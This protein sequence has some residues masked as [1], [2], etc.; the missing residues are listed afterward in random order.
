MNCDVSENGNA[1]EVCFCKGLIR[2]ESGS[3]VRASWAI[4]PFGILCLPEGAD[5]DLAFITSDQIA[6]SE[7]VTTVDLSGTD[8]ESVEVIVGAVLRGG[9]L[10]KVGA[11]DSGEA[12]LFIML[13]ELLQEFQRWS[14]EEES[15]ETLPE[16]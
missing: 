4:T 10:D 3:T 8:L 2:T 9:Y 12:A 14:D 11:K 15:E 7:P 13:N 1:V 5:E 16:Q 6:E